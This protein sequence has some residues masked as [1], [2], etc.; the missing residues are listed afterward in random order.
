MLISNVDVI[1]HAAATVRF[2]ENIKLAFSINVN[3]TRDILNLARQIKNL[4]VSLNSMF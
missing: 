3:G 4:K 1:F 2:D